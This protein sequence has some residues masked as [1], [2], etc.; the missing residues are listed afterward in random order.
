MMMPDVARAIS[1]ARSR[2]AT[3]LRPQLA[4]HSLAHTCTDVVP[5]VER[6]AFQL[7]VGGEDLVLLRTAAW[8][9]DI[10]FVTQYADHETASICIAATMLPQFGYTNTQLAVVLGMIEATRLNQ[11]PSTLLESVL[12][13]ADLDSLGRTDFL[14][15]SL[16]LRAELDA[17]GMP[18]SPTAWYARQYQ[19]LV[20]HHY[21]TPAARAL[22]DRQ[23]QA[24]IAL[25]AMLHKTAQGSLP[26]IHI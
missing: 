3:D 23:K 22:R 17:F 24:N 15:T 2:L 25:L 6:L 14:R 1:Y 21:Y 18:N 20:Q 11:I 19:F 4:Y 5:A 9:H 12:A 16:A 8:Y 26:R 10:G 7:G 13:D